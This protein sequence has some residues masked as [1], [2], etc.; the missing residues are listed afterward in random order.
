MPTV[1]SQEKSH[2]RLTGMPAAANNSSHKALRA[3]G[4]AKALPLFES[5]RPPARLVEDWFTSPSHYTNPAALAST[6]KATG[7]GVGRNAARDS[8]RRDQ[9]T[10]KPRRQWPQAHREESS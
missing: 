6:T 9:R 3:K 2:S 4:N 5:G 7:C 1:D 10:G 8:S